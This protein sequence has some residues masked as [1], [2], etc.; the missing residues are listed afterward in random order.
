MRRN[1]T[2]IWPPL[3]PRETRTKEIRKL[4]KMAAKDSQRS[5]QNKPKKTLKSRRRSSKNLKK[6]G[7]APQPT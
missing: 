4:R 1:P 3:I 5:S 7:V 6:H 2:K